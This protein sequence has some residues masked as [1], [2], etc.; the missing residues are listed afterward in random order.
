MFFKT[1][2]KTAWLTA[3]VLFLVLAVIGLLLPIIP[4]M[5]FFLAAIFCL[6]RCSPRFNA[7]LGRQRLYIRFHEWAEKKHWFERI[8][9]HIPHRQK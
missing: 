9:K 8:R 1:L 2:H 7:W 5:P 4:Q 3:G 6:V